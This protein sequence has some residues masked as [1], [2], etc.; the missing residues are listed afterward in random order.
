MIPTMILVGLALGRWWRL[1]L[2]AGAVGWPLLLLVLGVVGPGG[3]L[4][5]A[6]VGV[7]NA[8]VGVVVV[9]GGLLLGRRLRH[10]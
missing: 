4:P 10:P 5:A 6:V 8:G 2:V 3:V 1:A 7:L 9:Q